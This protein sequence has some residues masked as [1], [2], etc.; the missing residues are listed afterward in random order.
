MSRTRWFGLA[1][2]L[3]VA[4]CAKA[5]VVEPPPPVT[6][7]I[8]LAAS[9]DVN[10]DAGGRAS[11]LVVRV[12]ELTDAS[13]FMAAD[14][15]ALWSQEAQVMA[16]TPA[17]RQEFTLAPNGTATV[18]LHLEP[19]VQQIGVAAAF[20]DIRNSN[21]RALVA[22]SQDPEAPRSLQLNVRAVGKSVTAAIEKKEA[23]GATSK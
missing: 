7:A 11:P 13:A 2:I 18:T 19:N 12:Y 14:F 17:K 10:P 23:V 16:A 22:V 20:R 8:T 9:G 4:G 3:A 6:V 15:F 21:W 5:P 1:A